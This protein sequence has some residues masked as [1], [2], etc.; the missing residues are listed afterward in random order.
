[1]WGR[2]ISV[3]IAAGQSWIVLGCKS[4]GGG[5]FALVQAFPDVRP[6]FRTTGNGIFFSGVKASGLG[7]DHTSSSSA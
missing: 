4:D 6:T 3:R 1:M 2:R 5:S 7:V